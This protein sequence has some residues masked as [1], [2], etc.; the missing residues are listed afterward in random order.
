[1]ATKRT[2]TGYS[3]PLLYKAFA[4]LNEIAGSPEKMGISDLARELS[5]SKGTLHG[6]AQALLELGVITQNSSKKFSL[7]P[8]LVELGNRAFAGD[9]LRVLLRPS[10]EDLYREFK[11]TVFLGVTDGEK[12]TIIEKVDN[13]SGLKISA[14]VGSRIPLVAGAAGK[15][16]L[17]SF[18][19]QDLPGMLR[20]PLPGFT[21]NTIT[22]KAEYIEEIKKVRAQGFATDFEEYIQGVNA[23]CVPVTNIH[24]HT[25]AAI[26]MV[27]FTSTL[28]EKKAKR[29]LSALFRTAS[30]SLPALPNKVFPN[31]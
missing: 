29:A 14:P 1:M 2:A 19:D 6:I 16:F 24:G 3:A 4:M 12:I 8:T 21:D 9:D 23:V 10:M 5:M 30:K 15:V 26:W 20:D 7:G 18:P 27:G 25:T 31:R 28:D 11:E 13:P 22:G 17:A